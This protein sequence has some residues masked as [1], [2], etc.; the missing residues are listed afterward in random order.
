[1]PA[2]QQSSNWP[3]LLAVDVV[4]ADGELLRA[5]EDEHPDLFWALRGGGGKASIR[6][7]LRV[8]ES[9]PSVLTNS[10]QARVDA[11]WDLTNRKLPITVSYDLRNC[12]GRSR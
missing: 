5:T 9:T 4:T 3:I 7:W 1:M 2:R 10:G 8:N 12:P 11:C 6:L